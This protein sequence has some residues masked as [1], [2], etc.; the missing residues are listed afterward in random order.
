[1]DKGK[2]K[3]SGAGF[4]HRG[5]L[6]SGVG[7]LL[8]APAV[9]LLASVA[10]MAVAGGAALALVLPLFGRRRLPRTHRD[11]DCIVLDRDQYS[12]VDDTPQR[13]SQR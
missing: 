11:D 5:T 4:M 7:L 13:L 1:M 8:M 12:R 9:L 2:A 10:A 3:G 6:P